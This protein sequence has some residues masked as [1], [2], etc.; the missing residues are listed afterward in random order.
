M[1]FTLKRTVRGM[2]AGLALAAG[3]AAAQ[4]ETERGQS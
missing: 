2:L 3:Q 1:R 4:P